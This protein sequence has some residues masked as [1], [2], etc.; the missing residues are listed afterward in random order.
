MFR[1]S[2]AIVKFPDRAGT[3]ALLK[4]MGY[5][6]Y[7]PTGRSSESQMPGVP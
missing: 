6:D 3:R 7:D 2:G 1:R 4:S 5:S